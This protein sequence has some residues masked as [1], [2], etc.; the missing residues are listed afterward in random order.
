MSP[1][2]TRAFWMAVAFVITVAATPPGHAQ[3][4]GRSAVSREPALTSE[5]LLE[6]RRL[7]EQV[8]ELRE[9]D[10]AKGKQIERLERELH[11]IRGA[12][13]AAAATVPA[14]FVAPAP[15]TRPPAPTQNAESALDRVLRESTAAPPRDDAMPNAAHQESALDRALRD[16][17]RGTATPTIP[18]RPTGGVQFQLID[19]SADLLMSVGTSTE[20]D[21]SLSTLQ[22][23]HHDPRQRGFTFQ[24]FELGL[25]GAVDPYFTAEAI[26]NL[27]IAP[28]EG[29]TELELEEAFATS[30]ALPY[31]LQLEVGHFFTEF[32]RFNP[33]H[34]HAWH[35]Q[36][37]PVI[38]SRLFGEDGLRSTG[39]RLGWLLPVDWF[40]ELNVGLQ[41][42]HGETTV[43]F[44]ANDEVFA[45]RAIGGR[46]FVDRDVRSL[47]DML[48]HLRWVNSFTTHD[49][50]LTTL[51]GVSGLL[52]PNPTGPD[53]ATQVYGADLVMK[54]RPAQNMRGWPFL[55]SETEF[56]ARR[57]VADNFASIGDAADP[58]DD[59][60]FFGDTL[61]DY[62]FVTQ[63]VY[64]F[65]YRWA[66]GLRYEYATGSGAGVDDAG[67]AVNRN[68]DPFRDDR[69]RFS[70][71]LAFYATEYSR[72]RFQ[73]NFDYAEHLDA[74]DAHSFWLGAEFVLGAHPAH[75]F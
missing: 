10:D 6:L 56:M 33:I 4:D 29:E 13:V 37:Q 53:G 70:P 16:L 19:I 28:N 58:T 60:F 7:R 24:G 61:D 74:K 62:G 69:H 9:R 47:E 43:S 65:R 51:V 17:D 45:T 48:Y 32:G 14:G 22:A 31:N 11:A 66:G 63:L 40:S 8:E 1:Q 23:G 39:F 34:A 44:L 46:P 50:Q 55:I 49:E 38:H 3:D 26:L 57:Y 52:G 54:Y 75:R 64:G 12:P 71:L 72:V 27:L 21:E 15:G 20:P 18:G 67:A 2:P 25:L 68:R 41:V 36:D 59:R 42:P 35:W 5:L 30:Q 73:Y